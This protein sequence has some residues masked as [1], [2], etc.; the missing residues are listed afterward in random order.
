MWK[1]CCFRGFC[2]LAPGP[3]GRVAYTRRDPDGE[4]HPWEGCS[5]GM[6]AG[7]QDAIRACFRRAQVVEEAVTTCVTRV[8]T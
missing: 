4:W 2:V 8:Y 6:V 3:L 7:A 5:G 1:G